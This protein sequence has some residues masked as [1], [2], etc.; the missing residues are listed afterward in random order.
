MSMRDAPRRGQRPGAT[1]ICLAVATAALIT[2]G[3]CGDDKSSTELNAAGPPMVRQVFVQE[4]EFTETSTTERFGLAFGDH[5]D[6]PSKDE[7]AAEG[8]DRVVDNAV[9]FGTSRLRVVLDELVRGND[10]EEV[11]CSD[12]SYSR[13]P[14][15]TD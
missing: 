1:E 2:A 11:E 4:K 5:P 13:V 14:V 7:D 9:A 12:G 10:I 15:G 3:A 6:I 8:D